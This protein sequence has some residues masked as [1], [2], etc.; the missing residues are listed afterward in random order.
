MRLHLLEGQFDY[1]DSGS[2]E[3]THLRFF[4]LRTALDV[5]QHAGF[6]AAQ[7]VLMQPPMRE[8]EFKLHSHRKNAVPVA[9][10]G[11]DRTAYTYQFLFHLEQRPT[12]MTTVA[13]GRQDH[14]LRL[15][16]KP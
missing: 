6:H 16:V 5:F 11:R 7:V 1:V 12:P 9:L 10:I 15:L 2:L 3:R 14:V 13:V 4:T 8:T